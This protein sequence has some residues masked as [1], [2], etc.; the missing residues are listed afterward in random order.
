MELV[1]ESCPILPKMAFKNG[2]SERLDELRFPSPRSPP[3]ESAFPG[4]NSLSPGHT[5]FVSA[6]PRSSGDVRANLQRRFTTDSSKL[7]SW[8]YLNQVGGPSQVAD[9][10]DLLSSFEKKRQHIEYMREQR[11]RFEEDMKLLDMQH[12]KEKQEMD[13]LARDLAKAGLSGPVSEPTTPPEY[14]ERGFAGAFTRPTRFSTSSV[15]SS[16]GFFNVFAPSQ[17]T[18]PPSQTTHSSAHTPTNRFSVHSV[19]GSRRNSEKEDFAQE[20]TSPFRPGPSIHR[21]SM[22]ST[23]LGS[24]IRPNIAAFSN[25]SGLDSFSAAKYLFHNEDD[26]ATVT[27]EDRI[28]TPDIKSYLKLTDPDDKFP[29]LSRRSDS[30]LLSANSDALDLANSRTPNPETW[31]SHS[32][33]R[34]SHQSMPQNALNMF[35]LDQ[36]GN[37]TSESHAQASNPARHIARHSLEA[38]LLHSQEGGHGNIGPAVSSRPTSLQTSYSTN[39]VPTIKGDGFN[40]AITPPK[41]HAESFQQ[42]NTSLGRLPANS[43]GTQQ[44]DAVQHDEPKPQNSLT[45]QTTLQAS[46]PPFGPQLTAAAVTQNTVTPTAMTAFPAPFYGYGIQTYM[47]NPVQVNGQLQNFSPTAPYGAYPPYGN[48]RLAEGQAKGVAARRS[49]D[50]DSNQLSRFTNFPL[51]HYRGELYTL[52]KDQHGCRYLQRKLEE[53]NPEH[54]QLIFD[55]TNM[56]VVELMTDPFGNYLCQKLLEFSNDEQRTALINNA[57]NQLVK[58]ALNQHGTRALQKMIEFISTPEQ[59]QTV[60]QALRDHV[61]E[62]VQDLNGNH[63]IQKCLNRLSAEDAQ[64]IYDA[65]GANCVVVGTHRHGCC[66]LQRCIDHASGEQRARLIAQITANAFALVQ[67]PFGNYVVQYILDLAEPHFTEPLCQAFRGNIPALSKQKFS[68]NVIEKCLR[69][70]EFQMRRQMIDEM[71]AGTELEKMLRD[72]FANYVVQTAM[73]FA[74]PE[75]RARIVDA[76]R[77]IL[78]SIR[79]TPHGR[80]I[81]GKM[82]ASE[83]SGRGS[84]ATSGQVT[85]NEMNSAQLPGPLQGPQ[86]PFLY[87][88]NS[89]PAP[90]V[91]PQFGSQNF[92][93]ASGS[94]SVSNTTS[95][96]A[97]DNSSGIYA[98]AAQQPNGNIGAQSQLYAYF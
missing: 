68:S 36:L 38:T 11:R 55:E 84:A 20:T 41:A 27:E 92:M 69:T 74:D 3:S 19:P 53:R 87:Q 31:N 10:L 85:P 61:V 80:R 43:I 16:P 71:L 93:P 90:T 34:S 62:L 97:S 77:P 25:T 88:H 4:Y 56:H 45:Q 48:Y 75:T 42:H 78:P 7:S 51:E 73:D 24:Q 79:Q 64:F 82:M 44:K 83:G 6:F 14:R 76:I 54:V 17:V 30:G 8:S 22:P 95:G 28:P 70:A 67:D 39:D 18:S 86:K 26:R 2:L 29:T 59:I 63:V 32:R 98:P 47:G 50:G 33:H 94:G 72:S 35:R 13:Q 9:P 46:A 65:V 60:I 40:P 12:E 58:I 1:R 52:C 49:G 21:Y 57:A 66:V 15:T 37:S 89:F 96:G 81:A 91:G 5:S 23:G